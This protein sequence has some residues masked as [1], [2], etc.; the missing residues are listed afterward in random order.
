MGGSRERLEFFFP[1]ERSGSGARKLFSCVFPSSGAKELSLVFPSSGAT[2]ERRSFLLFEWR[3][4]S[5][6]EVFRARSPPP[7]LPP[8]SSLHLFCLYLADD[9]LSL[10]SSPPA[11]NNNERGFG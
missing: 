1:F 5:K 6:F 4:N 11:G 2:A 7:P 3:K 9:A 10:F 8:L